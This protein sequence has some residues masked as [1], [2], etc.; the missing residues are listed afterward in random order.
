[1][2]D[3]IK[4]IAEAIFDLATETGWQTYE[5]DIRGEKVHVGFDAD[6]TEFPMEK[7][8]G[9]RRIRVESIDIVEAERFN[10]NTGRTFHFRGILQDE[11]NKKI[12]NE[13]DVI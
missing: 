4:T 5:D 12:E 3:E 6:V 10:E 8:T 2:R 7:T 13:R 1:M 11:I 9:Y